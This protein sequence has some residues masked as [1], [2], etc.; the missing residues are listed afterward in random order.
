MDGHVHGPRRGVAVAAGGRA[1]AGFVVTPAAAGAPRVGSGIDSRTPPRSISMRSACTAASRIPGASSAPSRITRIAPP[2]TCTIACPR[3][4]SD[5]AATPKRRMDV[6]V[7]V[8]AGWLRCGSPNRRSAWP[9]RADTSVGDGARAS[10]RGAIQVQI[11]DAATAAKRDTAPSVVSRTTP[12]AAMPGRA[13]V[14]SGFLPAVRSH[15]RC[16]A[17]ARA[18]RRVMVTCVGDYIQHGREKRL[19]RACSALETARRCCFDASPRSDGHYRLPSK[20]IRWKVRRTARPRRIRPVA[21]H[22][23]PLDRAARYPSASRSSKSWSS[24]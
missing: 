18:R 8:A 5:D 2:S 16:G 11:Q 20:A 7:A 13:V 19:P 24:W 15:R 14:I 9:G 4:P 22:A 10:G 12:D 3:R 21:R 23:A 6:A 17:C 1:Y